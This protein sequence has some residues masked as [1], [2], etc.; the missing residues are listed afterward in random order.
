[1]RVEKKSSQDVKRSV[2]F[3]SDLI[4]VMLNSFQV[5][6]ARPNPEFNLTGIQSMLVTLEK[7]DIATSDNIELWCTLYDYSADENIVELI[8]R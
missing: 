4:D 6:K 8:P 3:L 7:L 5:E 1:M 2:V